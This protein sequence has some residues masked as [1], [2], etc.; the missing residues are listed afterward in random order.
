[1]AWTRMPMPGDQLELLTEAL[2]AVAY[3]AARGALRDL[4]LRF[5]FLPAFRV[6]A[7]TAATLAGLRSLH[8]TVRG[9]DPTR[10]VMACWRLSATCTS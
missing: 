7:A 1:M 2:Q 10:L 8:L 3:C 6:S 4:Y 9:G 5:E